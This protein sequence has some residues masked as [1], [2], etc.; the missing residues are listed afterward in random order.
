MNKGSGQRGQAYFR[1]T[2]RGKGARTR[3]GAWSS[4][5]ATTHIDLHSGDIVEQVQEVL[6][7]IQ[8]KQ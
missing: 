6:D 1:I 2:K 3:E 5:P 8:S 4:D 7:K